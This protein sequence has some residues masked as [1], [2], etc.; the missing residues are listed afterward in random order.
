MEKYKS[1]EARAETC[2]HPEDRATVKTFLE[3]IIERTPENKHRL[4]TI[5]SPK[6]TLIRE[7]DNEDTHEYYQTLN[8]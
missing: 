2:F 6:Y 1:I 7:F 4:I 5:K 3:T 8:T